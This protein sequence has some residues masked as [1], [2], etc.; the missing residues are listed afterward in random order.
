MTN[1]STDFMN[2]R[3]T[4]ANLFITAAVLFFILL[5]G[6]SMAGGGGGG[7]GGG[8]GDTTAPGIVITSDKLTFTATPFTAV[9]TFSEAVTGFTLDDITVGNGTADDFDTEDNTVFTALITPAAAGQ[10]TVDVAAG[11][12]AD[13][14]LN[15]NTA[16]DQYA[17]LYNPN[18]P[19]VAISTASQYVNTSPIPVTITFTEQ[20][21]GFDDLADIQVTDG[22]GSNLAT[23]DNITFT[24]D[25]TP[26]GDTV[27][28]QVPENVCSAAD[29]SSINCASDILTIHYDTEA[30]SVILST[31][32][33][34]PTDVSPIP[35]TISFSE[36]VTGF[37]LA[38]IIIGN[39]SAAALDSA[40]NIDFT[41]DITPAA[42]GAVTIDVPAGVCTDL[43]GNDNQ[44]AL[45][46]SIVYDT[47]KIGF[48]NKQ[49]AS[50]VIGQPDFTSHSPNQGGSVGANT[51]TQSYGDPAYGA[52]RLFLPDY[53]NNRVLV[54]TSIPT[55][56]NQSA[57]YVIGQPN[58]TSNTPGTSSTVIHG[59]E[60][61]STNGTQLMIVDY[62]NNRILIYNTIPSA[63]GAAADV[64][65]GQTDFTSSGAGLSAEK[66]SGP[67]SA[68]ITADKL[69]IADSLN[70]RVLIF[71]S[72]P[73]A[74][75]AAAD[76]VLGQTDFTSNG[77]G[78]SAS[79]LRNPTD[80]WSDGTRVIVSDAGNNRI[81]IWNTFPTANGQP[82]DVVVGQS[83]FTSG[84]AGTAADRFNRQW[85]FT[86]SAVTN[87]LFVTDL[88]NHRVLIF[89]T[90]PTAN[91]AAADVVL[92]QATF[93]TK[94]AGCTQSSI[95]WPCGI[96]VL[97]ET[98]II[99]IDANN[100]RAL[101]FEGL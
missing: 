65:V 96:S 45:E 39:G 91:G 99:M 46:L 88:D 98:R 63:S 18:A 21:T 44:A 94:T 83:T 67:E 29:D 68:F 3:T 97:D 49:N 66:I 23:A 81:L 33:G 62:D 80:V 9:F 36:E 101:I 82:A 86:A 95:N 31:T 5:C 52:G 87:Q 51:Y 76:V 77:S 57:D 27:T 48:T 84:G 85:N 32:S 89:N 75:G 38:D 90:I 15:P 14:A 40:D 12:A 8:N 50:V 100:N 54:F 24:L 55:S 58:L 60:S 78:T 61:V 30:P 93:T 26:T 71:D 92:G 73:A 10:V 6:C 22:T 11:A 35:V 4:P 16:A 25:I 7:N 37:D 2:Y 20:V 19:G 59:P 17:I 70:N 43:A 13:A 1:R 34:N 41:L 47:V 74:N 72:I 69:L 42:E 28:V 79:T 64:V 53:G 56:N